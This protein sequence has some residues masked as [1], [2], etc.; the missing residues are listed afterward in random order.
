MTA[1]S[2]S[3]LTLPRAVWRQICA[4]AVREWPNEC[5]GM[6]VGTSSGHVRAAYE[7]VNALAQ[8]HRFLSEPASLFAA[9]RRRRQEGWDLLGFYH[10]HPGGR[11]VPS[12]VDTDPAVNYW[13][14]GSVVTLIVALYPTASGGSVTQSGGT[15]PEETLFTLE[16]AQQAITARFTDYALEAR[17][18]RLFPHHWQQIELLLEG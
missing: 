15:Q 9:E 5:L 12:Q 11:P 10:S 2:P 14:D 3:R 7:L 4:Q 13:L 18:Y 16:L 1:A 6:L 8:P 17:A